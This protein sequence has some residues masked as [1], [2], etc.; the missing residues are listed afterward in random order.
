MSGQDKPGD[1]LQDG[2]AA[3]PASHD[4]AAVQQIRDGPEIMPRL[5]LLF[6]VAWTVLLVA[7]F[8][9]YMEIDAV[10]D[11]FPAKLGVLPFAVIWFGAVGGL[12]ISLEG[13]FKYNRAW[14]PSYNYWHYLRPVVGAIIGTLGCL[15]FIVLTDAAAKGA[16]AKPNPIFYDVVALSIGYREASFRALIGRLI[17]AVILPPEKTTASKTATDRAAE[18]ATSE[19]TS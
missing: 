7:A 5:V 2:A 15:V 13:I 17:D 18:P 14:R 9:L 16:A 6:A 1:S 19:T 3:A 11:F 4:E 8:F 10:A 12:V